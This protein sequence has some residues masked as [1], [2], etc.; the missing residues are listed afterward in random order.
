MAT[1]MN[2]SLPDVMKA[3]VDEQ[4]QNGGFGTVSEY[5]RDLVR[6]DEREAGDSEYLGTGLRPPLLE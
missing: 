3:F 5:L 6:R 4:V 2:M 1:T